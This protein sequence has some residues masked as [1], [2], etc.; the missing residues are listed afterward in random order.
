MIYI[1]LFL[2]CPLIPIIHSGCI[3]GV[4]LPLCLVLVRAYK[5]VFFFLVGGVWPLCAVL[6]GQN[7]REPGP[8]QSN[9][10][11]MSKCACLFFLRVLNFVWCGAK[12][13]NKSSAVSISCSYFT[14][15][16]TIDKCLIC[17]QPK[18][19]L[20]K[21]TKTKALASTW[22]YSREH[23]VGL[24]EAPA[25]SAAWVGFS[26]CPISP[27]FFQV[28]SPESSHQETIIFRLKISPGSCAFIPV[29][30]LRE[31]CIVVPLELL[32]LSFLHPI[33]FPFSF[34]MSSQ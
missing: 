11:H 27:H 31:D 22:G 19:G 13:E 29:M 23:P 2:N 9:S 32:L 21:S 15:S 34:P 10:E 18:A 33:L 16:L 25:A 12:S 26:L 30:S 6:E 17:G 5:W 24:A 20:E 3:L 1:S 8:L 14:A 7:I 28:L 4:W